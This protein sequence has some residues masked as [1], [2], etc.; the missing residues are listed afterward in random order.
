MSIRQVRTPFRSFVRSLLP[1]PCSIT[2]GLPTRQ[3][4]L[5]LLV[6]RLS[7]L[8]PIIHRATTPLSTSTSS[9]P[10][11]SPSRSR[12]HHHPTIFAS[13]D[14]CRLPLPSLAPP[15]T[16][17]SFKHCRRLPH[18]I[19]VASLIPPSSPPLFIIDVASLERQFREEL[20]DER[21]ITSRGNEINEMPR[22]YG[23]NMRAVRRIL[24]SKTSVPLFLVPCHHPYDVTH[25]VDPA[26]LPHMVSRRRTRA[27]SHDTRG[28]EER[29]GMR[30]GK[31][32]RR[33]PPG[34]A[35]AHL[36]FLRTRTINVRSA[37]NEWAM[38]GRW[39]GDGWAMS[40]RCLSFQSNFEISCYI[41]DN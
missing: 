23:C 1:R 30:V 10:S 16:P 36:L 6:S 25:V 27:A 5:P 3:H 33:C 31:A 18:S 29:D 15:S 41:S 7:P 20:A 4:H 28:D 21:R 17:P 37:G 24:S 38:G 22:M 12:H 26:T 35:H 11:L 34:L 32:R 8:A 2:T 14:H 40:G 39:V 9:P 13:L 19:V